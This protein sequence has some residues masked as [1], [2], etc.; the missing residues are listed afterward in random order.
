MQYY[1][2]EIIGTFRCVLKV[3]SFSAVR[4]VTEDKKTSS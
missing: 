3:Y 2:K 4:Y 1:K